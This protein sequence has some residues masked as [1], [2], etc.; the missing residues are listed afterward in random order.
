MFED[1][2][3]KVAYPPGISI[4]EP[5]PEENEYLELITSATLVC[6]LCDREGTIERRHRN[7][8]YCE[9]LDDLNYLLSCGECFDRDCEYYD[10]MWRDYYRGVL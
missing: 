8:K 5:V 10:E 2:N 6:P 7:T 1:F 9:D 3:D 4:I